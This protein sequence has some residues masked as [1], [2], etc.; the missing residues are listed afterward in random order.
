MGKGGK[1][2]YY[3]FK[4]FGYLWLTI[5]CLIIFVSLVWSWKTEGFARV[6]YLLSPFNIWNYAAIFITLA[7]GLG[8]LWLAEKLNS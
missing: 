7:P 3:I 8:A 6:R 4:Y 2:L 5:A 1:A